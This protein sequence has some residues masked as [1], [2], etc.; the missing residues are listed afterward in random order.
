M[1]GTYGNQLFETQEKLQVINR[2][3]EFQYSCLL[4]M[5]ETL[6]N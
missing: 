1:A 6:C 3:Q 5:Y 2:R 4:L